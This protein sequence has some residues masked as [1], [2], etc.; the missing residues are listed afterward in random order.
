LEGQTCLLSGGAPPKSDCSC[1]V[2]D[3]LPFLTHPIVGPRGQLAHR[4]LSG[5]HQTVWCAQPTVAAGHA[6]PTDRAADRWLTRQSSAPPDSPVNY[7]RT[8]LRFLESSRFTAG[9]P[10]APDMF[11]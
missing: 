2:R 1:L 10:G 6:S 7:S 11:P 5:A 8:P 3:L 4:T 9:Q